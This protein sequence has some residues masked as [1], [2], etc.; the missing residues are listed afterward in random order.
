[1]VKETALRLYKHYLTLKDKTKAVDMKAHILRKYKIDPEQEEK[2]E[3]KKDGK[4]S[5]R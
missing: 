3:V 5:K 1:M 2:K 4:K